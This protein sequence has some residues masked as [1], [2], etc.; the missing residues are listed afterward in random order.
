MHSPLIYRYDF[1]F[2]RTSA[3][4]EYTEYLRVI[5]ET[6]QNVINSRRKYYE[7]NPMELNTNEN[8]ELGQRKRMPLIDTLLRTN[9]EGTALSNQDI[10][11]EVNTFLFA[12]S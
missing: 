10:E 2:K 1:I 7:E 3:Y 5:S 6:T 9:V 11:D 12:V 4:K 8:N